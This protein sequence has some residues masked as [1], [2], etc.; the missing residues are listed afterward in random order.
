MGWAGTTSTGT[1]SGWRATPTEPTRRRVFCPFQP[2]RWHA[3]CF[4]PTGIPV[5]API[6]LHPSAPAFRHAPWRSGASL[7]PRAVTRSPGWRSAVQQRWPAPNCICGSACLPTH[8][9]RRSWLCWPSAW[10]NRCRVPNW[11]N[12]TP[13]W[14]CPSRPRTTSISWGCPPRPPAPPSPAS[15]G[16]T[17][18][19]CSAC[20]MPAHCGWARPIWTSS[21]PA[22]W[23]HARPT[24]G[25]AAPSTPRASAVAPARAR[26]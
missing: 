10:P 5:R 2:L 9:G 20:S 21:L 19:W 22:W 24:V 17:P 4:A 25:R 3:S 18:P 15:R 12:A 14:A 11:C 26:R 6:C 8:S 16:T 13:C 1:A 23:A 7:S